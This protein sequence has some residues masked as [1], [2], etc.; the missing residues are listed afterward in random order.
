MPE[1]DARRLFR[2]VVD[3]VVYLHQKGICHRDIKMENV[4][5]DADGNAR[6]VDFG[7]A[8]EGGAD[9]FLMSMQGTPAYMAPE[10]AQQKA[11][12]GGP[13]DV[14][15]LGVLLYNLVSGGAFPFWGKDMNDLRRN[16]S[17]APLKI[18]THLSA[19][20]KDLLQRLLQKSSSTR[21]SV[22]DV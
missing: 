11:H 5:L 12:K 15:A 9:T 8:K 17:A 18:P 1:P 22:A 21:L 14:W 13:A 7:A 20:C 16:I 4:V 2:Q 3:A 6:L 10:V 19:A